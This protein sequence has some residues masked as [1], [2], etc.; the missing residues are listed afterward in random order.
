MA[1]I[2]ME[3]EDLFI[4]FSEMGGEEPDRPDGARG[5]SARIYNDY[6]FSI[7]ILRYASG[8]YRNLYILEPGTTSIDY[9]TDD[10][11]WLAPLFGRRHLMD[12][13]SGGGWKMFSM[14]NRY[15]APGTNNFTHVYSSSA[16]TSY[17]HE[18]EDAGDGA[19]G[20]GH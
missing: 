9:W 13:S 20:R 3:G 6:L 7:A 1:E 8:A 17:G 11:L 19:A 5:T 4:P 10:S 18:V 16:S 2:D 15:L 12:F 14:R